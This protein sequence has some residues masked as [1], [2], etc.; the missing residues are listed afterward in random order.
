MNYKELENEYE[1]L[2]TAFCVYLSGWD[3]IH[4][5]YSRYSFC[6]ENRKI[7]ISEYLIW[8]D[9][10]K[11]AKEVGFEYYCGIDDFLREYRNAVY[12]CLNL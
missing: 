10:V 11:R 4:R 9:F 6:P 12:N 1:A 3:T 7:L 2:C 8:E 5:N